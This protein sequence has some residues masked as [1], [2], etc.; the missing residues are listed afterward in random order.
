MLRKSFISKEEN[1]LNILVLLIF[2]SYLIVGISIF[3]DYGISWDEHA[4]RNMGFVALNYLRELFSLDIFTGFE[5]T[6]KDFADSTKHYG[7]LFDLPMAFI[8][9][10]FNVEDSKNYFLVR[11]F[12]NFIIFYLSGIFFYFLLRK[13][14]TKFLSIIGLLFWIL[15]PRFFA[16]SFY[17]MKDIIFLSFFIIGLFYAINFINFPTYINAFLSALTCSLAIDVRILGIIIPFIVFVFFIL[18]LF[19]KKKLLTKNLSYLLIFLIFLIFFTI[20][21]WPYLWS[22][23]IN[24]FIKAFATMSSYPMRLSVFYLGEYV[25]STNLPWHYPLVWVFISTPIVYL[26]FF[27]FG[28]FLILI[29]IFTRFSELSAEKNILDPWKGNNEKMDLIFFLI[30]YF[31]L[32]LVIEMNSTLYGG[33]RHLFFIYPSLI[34]I[35]IRGIEFLTRYIKAK[36]IFLLL[37]PYFFYTGL[38]IAK[39]HPYQFVFFNKFAGKNISNNFELDY[40]GTSN[41]SALDYILMNDKNDEINIYVASVSP[42][43]FSTLLLEKSERERIKFVKNLDNA[44]FLVT[45]HYYQK[46]NPITINE[47]LKKQFKLLKE[48]KVD[49]MIIN[50]VFKID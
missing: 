2:S 50:S 12:F 43:Y 37:I 31:T 42:Y 22:D 46:G 14:F 11:H 13:R 20:L 7:V 10:F 17:N 24:N 34:F 39:N 6:D 47:K 44:N 30:F 5:Q 36:Y 29:K 41:K 27:T 48:F 9:K 26:I 45:N 16:D 35:S 49:N 23:P 1:L 4:N 18:T 19:D 25:S 40:W 28:S 8:E 32:F 21:F 3:D 15:S 38:W 33:W